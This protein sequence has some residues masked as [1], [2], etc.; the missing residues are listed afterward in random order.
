MHGVPAGVREEV[1][2]PT[3]LRESLIVARKRL[4]RSQRVVAEET[5]LD[6]ATIQRVEGGKM[7]KSS[8]RLLV[9]MWILRNTLRG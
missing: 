2:E 9:E 5:G 7:V 6:R 1:V 3:G 4:K 8:T